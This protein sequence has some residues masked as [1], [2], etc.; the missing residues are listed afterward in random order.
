[1]IKDSDFH[2]RKL[3]QIVKD[4][5]FHGRKLS[6][7]VEDS[8]FQ[9]SVSCGS[10]ICKIKLSLQEVEPPNKFEILSCEQNFLVLTVV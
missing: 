8:D 3:S 7:I 4:S 1:M 6:Q 10:I 5:N 2:G 9:S